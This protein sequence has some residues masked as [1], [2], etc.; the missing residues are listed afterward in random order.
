MRVKLEEFG[1]DARP[2]V[3]YTYDIPRIGETV[4]VSPDGFKARVIDVKHALL[5]EHGNLSEVIL[6]V[7]RIAED[8][9]SAT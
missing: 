1:S 4:L 3:Y 6:V 5:S 9:G 7:V 8:M 2:R